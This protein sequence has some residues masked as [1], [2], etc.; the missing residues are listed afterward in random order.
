[1]RKLLEKPNYEHAPVHDYILQKL[2]ALKVEQ[3]QWVEGDDGEPNPDDWYDSFAEDR[4]T[5]FIDMWYWSVPE[6]D[7]RYCNCS[8][9]VN[10]IKEAF[11]IDGNYC[12][13]DYGTVQTEIGGVLLNDYG[14]DPHENYADENGYCNVLA[15]ATIS[16]TGVVR[17]SQVVYDLPTKRLVLRKD[18]CY[19]MPMD[20][21]KPQLFGMKR[22]CYNT[23]DEKG[24]LVA[25][26]W[27]YI[28]LSDSEDGF[29]VG[30]NPK[31]TP[32]SQVIII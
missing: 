24:I 29:A 30:C 25:Y 15:F 12:N 18:I 20:T 4:S 5:I 14:L 21:V 17:Y 11:G 13:D 9:G 1:M 27:N 32:Q 8:V 26:D 6:G 10:D 16:D 3:R 19:N 31:N 28:S 7:F 23:K 22:A 2:L